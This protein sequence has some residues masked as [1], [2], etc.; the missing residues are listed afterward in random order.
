MYFVKDEKKLIR[1]NNIVITIKVVMKP[2]LLQ[3]PTESDSTTLPIAAIAS[4]V[5][6]CSNLEGNP[7]AK[8]IDLAS[9][10]HEL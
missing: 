8:R 2:Y 6:V 3:R 1:V 10:P 4:V 7:A 9:S 5:V